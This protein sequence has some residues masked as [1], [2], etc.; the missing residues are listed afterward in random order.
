LMAWGCW[1]PV[2]TRGGLFGARMRKWSVGLDIGGT[3]TVTQA[4]GGVDLW[5]AGDS[6]FE[7]L[8]VLEPGMHEGGSIWRPK[9]EIERYALVLRWIRVRLHTHLLERPEGP[10][11]P[12]IT[13]QSPLYR[14]DRG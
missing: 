10:Q 7:G 13:S 2:C 6:N 9:L 11:H 4:G 8:G 3:S 14:T 12:L 5:G 1:N